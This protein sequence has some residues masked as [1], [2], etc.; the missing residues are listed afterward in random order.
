MIY[1]DGVYKQ[2]ILQKE[3]EIFIINKKGDV[4]DYVESYKTF[5][6]SNLVPVEN[7]SKAD[8]KRIERA[9]YDLD[10]ILNEEGENKKWLI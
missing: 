4:I 7:L 8:V 5:K 10:W 1:W 9:G 6:F 3:K 2:F